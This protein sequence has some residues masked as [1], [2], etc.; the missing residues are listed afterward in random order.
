MANPE[1]LAIL[2]QGVKAWNRWREEHPNMRA[3]LSGVDLAEAYLYGADLRGTDLTRADLYKADLSM[4]NLSA[5]NVSGAIMRGAS[6]LNA[7]LTLARLERTNLIGASLGDAVLNQASVN[8]AN[9][10]T[11]EVSATVFADI[12]LSAVKGLDTALHR[13]PSYVDLQTIYK[14]RGNIPDVFL[15]GCGVPDDMIAFIRAIRG[16]PIEF[17]SCFISYSSKD[18]EIAKRLHADL[19][20]KGVRVW[21]APEDLKIGDKFGPRIDEAIRVY[22][23]LLLI[24][25]EHSIAS[26]WVEHE[27]KAGLKKEEQNHHTVLFPVRVDDA[28]METTDQWAHDLRRERHIG[29]FTKWKD[30]DCYQVAFARLLRDLQAAGPGG[31]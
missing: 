3:D 8:G 18:A 30:H 22:D 16:H 21:F 9:M 4:T 2:K 12:D 25:S 31:A 10:E 11:A 7:E 24:L 5:A 15:R 14:S 29:D 13:G 19:Q 6:L 17:Y 28:V 1:H 26:A 27:V 23:R 20:D